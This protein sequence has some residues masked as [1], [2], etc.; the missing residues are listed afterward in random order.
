MQEAKGRQAQRKQHK[1]KQNTNKKNTKT[2]PTATTRHPFAAGETGETGETETTSIKKLVQHCYERQTF[3]TREDVF[4]LICREHSRVK[5]SSENDQA[6]QTT[7]EQ[8]NQ[9]PHQKQTQTKKNHTKTNQSNRTSL[10][11][12]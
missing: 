1:N 2:K 10:S 6:N 4:T 9:R 5:A 3:F 12:W 8:R 7:K 11:P